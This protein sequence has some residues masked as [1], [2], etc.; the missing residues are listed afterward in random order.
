MT[1]PLTDLIVFLIYITGIVLFGASFYFRSRSSDAFTSGGGNIPSWVVGMSIFATFVSSISFLAL[2]GNAY[3]TNW[4][5]FVFSLSI[6]IAVFFAVKYFVP[7]YRSI[8]SVSAYSYLEKRFGPW[9][10]IYAS[11]CYLLTQ[12]ARM[13]SI[14]YLL[15]LP[16][17]ALFG[18]DIRIIIIVTGALVM[19]YSMMGGIQAVVWTDAIQGL[20]LISG[21]VACVLVLLFSMPVGPAQTFAIASEYDKFSLGSFSFD[22]SAS[23]FWV[24]LIYG[25]FI[26]LQ[27]YGIDQNYVQRYMTTKTEKEAKFSTWMGGIL[28]VPVSLLFFLIGTALFAYYK[29]HPELLPAEL[30]SIDM[31]DRVFPYFIVNGL[32]VGVTG[33]LIAAI[34]AAGMSTISTSLNS[35]ATIILTDYYQKY[36][37]N[38]SEK[39]SMMV[40]YVSSLVIGALGIMAALA[41]TQVKSALDAWWALSSIF[42]GGMLGLFLLGVIS[43]KTRSVDAA[44]GA[45][46]GVLLICWVSLSPTYFTDG[47]WVQFRSPLHTNLAIVV[48][49]IGIFVVGFCLGRFIHRQ[50]ESPK[51]KMSKP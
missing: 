15:A 18:W 36:A 11:A 24:I 16:M 30:S 6:P 27:N 51:K 26:N 9:A 34:F 21:A 49:T 39:S 25:L 7:L 1:L 41:M 33:L 48:G 19:F 37:D 3:Q 40:L 35:T 2:P 28:Y 31:A 5:G 8:N 14:L 42:S 17:N 46:V 47:V 4:N 50:K 13:G 20:V 10:R 45:V 29:V 44:I 38:I 23:T 43:R 22:F 32:P 12:L